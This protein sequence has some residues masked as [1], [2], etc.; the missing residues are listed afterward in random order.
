[1]N[2]HV[3]PPNSYQQVAAAAF[4]LRCEMEEPLRIARDLCRAL[5]IA[6]T[7]EGVIEDDMDKMVFFTLCNFLQ[8]EIERVE[9]LSGKIFHICHEAKF[10]RLPKA[11]DAEVEDE[12]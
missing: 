3:P 9:D 1:M 6:G 12:E 8:K 4:D 5:Y 11:V 10:G 7:G 2:A